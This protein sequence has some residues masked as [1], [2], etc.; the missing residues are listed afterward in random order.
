MQNVRAQGDFFKLLVLSDRQS[1]LFTYKD[2]KQQILIA[3]TRDL[4]LTAG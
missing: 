4:C 1:K 3:E 2:T